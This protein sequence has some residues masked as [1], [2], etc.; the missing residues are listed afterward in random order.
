MRPLTAKGG[1]TGMSKYI[2]I[3]ATLA[4]TDIVYA[5]SC[6]LNYGSN[7]EY[8]EDCDKYATVIT[9]TI[10]ADSFTATLLDNSVTTAD[11]KADTR[12]INTDV[13]GVIIS[14][15]E[16]VMTSCPQPP[17]KMIKNKDGSYTKIESNVQNAMICFENL[18][19]RELWTDYPENGGKFMQELGQ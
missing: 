5:E 6:W 12:Y 10:L 11:I 19:Y 14:V 2:I 17:D 18:E 4:M 3:I 1:I 15:K 8:V 7:I 16:K 9:A 13:S